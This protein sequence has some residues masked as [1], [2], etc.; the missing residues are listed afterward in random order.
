MKLELS[1]QSVAKYSY[2]KVHEN[3]SSGSRVVPCGQTWWTY[4]KSNLFYY[5]LH[6]YLKCKMKVQSNSHF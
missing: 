2:I 4:C 5:I 6:L 3:P 1:G